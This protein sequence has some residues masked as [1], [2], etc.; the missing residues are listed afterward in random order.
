MGSLGQTCE[1]EYSEKIGGIFRRPFLD[2]D[3]ALEMILTGSDACTGAKN[4]RPDA[5]GLRISGSHELP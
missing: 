4:K 3:P 1:S 5:A 2:A